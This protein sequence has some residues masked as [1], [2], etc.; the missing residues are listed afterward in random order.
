MA[1]LKIKAECSTGMRITT[2]IASRF[3]VNYDCIISQL[4]QSLGKI[5]FGNAF[6]FLIVLEGR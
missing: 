4:F 2:K 3:P 5:K 6:F 1:N